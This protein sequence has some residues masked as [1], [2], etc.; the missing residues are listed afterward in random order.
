M[1]ATF[2]LLLGW[3]DEC[4]HWKEMSWKN[5]LGRAIVAKSKFIVT[6]TPRGKTWAYRDLYVPGHSGAD[7]SIG[8]HAWR[9]IDNPYADKAYLEMMRRKLGPDYAA[10]ELDG[11]FV[12]SVGY[13]YSF[14]RESH[15][16]HLPSQNYNHYP[17]RVVGID[18][19]YGDPYAAVLCLRDAEHRWWIADEMYIPSKATFSDAYPK[20]SVWLKHWKVQRMYCDKRRPTDYIELGKMGLPCVPNID[21]FGEEDR[22]TIMPMVRIV[23][24]C[25]REDRLKIEP[26]CEWMIEELE[27]YAF[28]SQ[29]DR[30]RGENPVDYRNH[31]ADGLRYAIS[32]VESLPEDR[33]PRY[34]A[35]PRGVP[36]KKK[37]DGSDHPA[38]TKMTAAECLHA[39]EVAFLEE[40]SKPKS[41]KDRYTRSKEK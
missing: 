6:T 1:R 8:V 2:A 23:Q 37:L 18:P 22:R 12:D 14:D 5:M 11:M 24:R 25:F 26:H 32:S 33:Q 13:V 16:K 38:D 9:S 41:R 20:L 4:A 15:T 21:V 10:Q 27:N 39:Q 35:G 40:R 34:R 36:F 3:A 30:N 29:E 28:K 19:G 31:L 17:V 7:K